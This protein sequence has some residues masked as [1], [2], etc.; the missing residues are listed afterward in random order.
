MSSG[1]ENETD[2]AL[3]SSTEKSVETSNGVQKP[4]AATDGSEDLSSA[5][6][7][8]WKS[9]QLNDAA[10]PESVRADFPILSTRVGAAG[11]DEDE[12]KPL[13]YLDSA[14]T[15]QKPTYV[16]DKLT[17][18]YLKANSNV[19]RVPTVSPGRPPR[20]TRVREMPSPTLSTPRVAMRSSSRLVPPR[21]STSSPTHMQ[22]IHCKMATW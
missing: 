8:W 2:G 9:F 16:L 5:E 13:I 1:V 12:K 10:L 20:S 17:D 14:A 18:Y 3:D 15:S 11:A 21:R 4:D 19:H 6:A 7:P 22:G